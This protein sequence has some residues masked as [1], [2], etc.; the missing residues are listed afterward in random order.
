[1][2][3]FKVGI[4]LKPCPVLIFSYTRPTQV[5]I[6][7]FLNETSSKLDSSKPLFGFTSFGYLKKIKKIN[8]F[9]ER[10]NQILIVIK[11]NF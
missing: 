7:T 10:T 11:T 1:M 4:G 9:Q 8:N 2:A 5:S 3:V 6:L